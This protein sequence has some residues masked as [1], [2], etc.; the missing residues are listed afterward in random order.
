MRRHLCQVTLAILVDGSS[1]SIR[2]QELK[3]LRSQIYSPGGAVTT[4]CK[5]SNIS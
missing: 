1:P 2:T 5:Q 4:V 3:V